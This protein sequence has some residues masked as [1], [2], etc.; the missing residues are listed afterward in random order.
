MPQVAGVNAGGEA[1]YDRVT[2]RGDFA[3]PAPMRPHPAPAMLL[4]VA[5][6]GCSPGEAGTGFLGATRGVDPADESGSTEAQ[7]PASTGPAHDATSTTDVEPTSTGGDL[8]ETSE[9]IVWDMGMPDFSG[10]QPA[11]CRGKIDFLFVISAAGTMKEHQSRLIGAFPGFMNLIREHLPDFNVHILVANPSPKPSWLMPD[12]GLC[13]DDCD[14]NGA[15]PICGAELTACDDEIGAGITFPAGTGAT[16][17]RCELAGG[18]RY[19]M[20]SGQEV[21]GEFACVAQVGLG[22]SGLGGEAMVTA[23]TS[24][25][26]DPTDDDACNSGFL[27][28]D[29][30]LVITIIQDGY[31]VDSSGTVDDWMDALRDAKHGDEDAYTVLVL[32]T[33]VDESYG[34]LCYPEL[35]NQKKNRLRLLAQGV[36][37]GSVGSICA[38]SYL[39]FFAEQVAQ[40]VKLCDAFTP[41]G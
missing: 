17:H 39:P 12:C 9:A 22:G 36:R 16:N 37:H 41:P 20:S 25:F 29:A 30:L 15:P 23:L 28:D 3:Y 40:L 35:F 6:F 18:K 24:D 33:D 27:R 4:A 34:G 7:K 11:G 5:M 1:G 38:E 10:V 26:N 2:A 8:T 19:I 21:D 14:P 13:K 31:D 32:T